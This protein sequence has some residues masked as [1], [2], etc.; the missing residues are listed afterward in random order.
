M[1]NMKFATKK[2][3]GVKKAVAATATVF[4]VFV[5]F[6]IFVAPFPV[7]LLDSSRT[8]SLVITD[9]FGNPIREKLNQGE[10]LSYWVG[11]NEISPHLIDA[12]IAIEDA[13]FYKHG[14]VD[15]IATARA[16][17]QNITQ[18]EIVSGGSTITQQLARN[19]RPGKRNIFNKIIEAVMAVQIERRLSKK[20]I[21]YQYLNRIPYGNG[22]YGIESA[23]RIYLDKKAADLDIAESAFL[24]GLPS[25][26]GYYNPFKNYAAAKKRAGHILNV[27][28][29]RKLI[30]DEEWRAANK[31]KIHIVRTYR[32]FLAPH[33]ADYILASADK[34]ILNNASGIKTTIDLELQ[35]SIE[36]IVTNHITNL[37]EK[38]VTNAAVV[39]IKND[40]GEILAMVGSSEYFNKRSEGMNNGA[41][42]PRQPGSALKPFTYSVAILNDF[43][44]ASILPD[45]ER[46]FSTPEGDFIPQNYD[47]RFHGPVRLRMALA[48]SLNVPAIYTA[49]RLGPAKILD[50]LRKLGITTLRK[51]AS[52]YGVGI[53]LGNG[54]VSLLELTHAYTIFPNEGVLRPLKSI[55]S[56]KTFAG[57]TKK[58]GRKEK[59]KR[60]LPA[61]VAYIITDILSDKKAR[62]ATFG[63][64]SPLSFSFKVGAKTGTSSNF[65]DNWTIGFTKDITIG[66]WCGNFSGKPMENISGI[67]GAGP[68]FRDSMR[69]LTKNRWQGWVKKPKGL[70]TVRI[71]PVSGK[72]A[73]PDC[74]SSVKEI[75]IRGTEPAEQCDMHKN[76]RID[77]R[78]GLLAT[79]KCPH[80]FVANKTFIYYPPEYAEWEA[81]ERI[82]PPPSAYSPL[83]GDRVKAPGDQKIRIIFPDDGA[84]FK[85]DPEIPPEYRSIILR[86][87]VPPGAGRLQ[88]SINGKKIATQDSPTSAVWHIRKGKF[89]ITASAD[90]VKSDSA[91]II[92]K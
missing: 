56:Y 31:E 13:R 27:M 66:V 73:G 43:T 8:A 77:M 89:R 22:A 44:A 9:R 49:N 23:A 16:L 82:Q 58:T 59:T 80:E 87:S 36:G 70:K 63:I 11:L 81:D 79:P 38:K 50:F 90:G 30:T 57:E 19:L 2:K 34:S 91:S 83:C 42:A 10:K 28:R 33:F 21:L 51:G 40:T 14:G 84:K 64:S 88:W 47:L 32:P 12:T 78:N 54:S 71:C 74:G 35:K 17:K 65:R 53:T 26:P 69:T 76:V 48:N 20:E 67:T 25:A 5:L 37:A 46:H 92:V 86:A 7:R 18:H 4:V 29:N 1:S 41:L 60:V 68:I 61:R 75:F 85:I 55:I 24:A 62:A 45:I 72:L 15:F 39:V 6:E 3:I 52:N